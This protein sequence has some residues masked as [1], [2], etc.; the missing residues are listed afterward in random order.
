M[1]VRL[2]VH[3]ATQAKI[4]YVELGSFAYLHD[5]KIMQILAMTK[6]ILKKT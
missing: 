6:I 3:G 2:F 1:Y 5:L 4:W